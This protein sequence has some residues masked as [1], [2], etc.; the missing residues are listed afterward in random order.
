MGSTETLAVKDDVCGGLYGCAATLAPVGVR[1]MG[2]VA[3]IIFSCEGMLSKKSNGCAED[4]PGG[5]RDPLYK[6]RWFSRR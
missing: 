3:G 1:G 5:G 4:W 2:S 6:V